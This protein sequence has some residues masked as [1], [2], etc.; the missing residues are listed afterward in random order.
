[1][2]GDFCSHTH[3]FCLHIIPVGQLQR[4][5]CD[6]SMPWTHIALA[7]LGGC[8]QTLADPVQLPSC[9]AWLPAATCCRG[10]ACSPLRLSLP[11]IRG[12]TTRSLPHPLPPPFTSSP[13][14]TVAANALAQAIQ[15]AAAAPAPPAQ[16]LPAVTQAL[17]AIQNAGVQAAQ[18][19]KGSGGGWWTWP[20]FRAPK[21]FPL[22]RALGAPFRTQACRQPRW[23][24]GL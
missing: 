16:T 9:T 20:G 6:G 8:G 22:P 13:A 5:P 15:Q 23:T 19:C 10:C 18:V 7:G 17:G 11:P 2:L 21:L 1:M 4:Q 3:F 12:L 14:G 24:R